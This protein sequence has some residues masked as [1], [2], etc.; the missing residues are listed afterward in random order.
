M[1]YPVHIGYKVKT[2]IYKIIKSLEKNLKPYI[3][4]DINHKLNKHKA[5]LHMHTYKHTSILTMHV[6][7]QQLQ[8]EI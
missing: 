6:Y 5:I 1:V 8:Y 4:Q 2:N 3:T 7:E